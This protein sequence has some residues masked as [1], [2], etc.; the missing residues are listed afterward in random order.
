MITRLTGLFPI[1]VLFQLLSYSAVAAEARQALALDP[2]VGLNAYAALVEQELDSARNGLRV[3]AVTENVVSGDWD[4]IKG[5]LA[6]FAKGISTSA[7]VWFARPDGSY[8]TVEAGL[9]NE[10]LKDRHYFPDLMD[11]KEIE[12]DLVVSKSTGQR[13]TIIAVPVRN[14]GHVIGALGVSLA[15]EKVAAFIDGK[16][17][18][19]QPVMFY[20]LDRHGQIALH[21]ESTLLFDFAAELG[22]PTLTEAV[23]EM[24]SRPEGTVHYE[25]AGA[26]RTAIFKTSGASGWVYAL[27]W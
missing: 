26:E 8:F 15:M 22:S 20:A 27:R 5:P 19:P 25:F 13:S 18:F 6:Q 23:K 24:L 4:R 10:N 14:D 16:M 17:R 12:G 2:G 9:T 7:A 11:G 3:L 21:R 1:L